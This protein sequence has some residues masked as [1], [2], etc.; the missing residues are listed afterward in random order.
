MIMK[1]LNY[2][3]VIVVEIALLITVVSCKKSFLQVPA[4]G[5]LNKETLANER[6]LQKLLTG[7]YAD[8]RGT[9]IPNTGSAWENSPDN[10]IYG[11]IAGGESH[12]GSFGGDQPGIN[13]IETWNV[14]PSNGFLNDRW[15]GLYDGI[16]RAN[17]VL[18][19]VKETSDVSKEKKTNIIAQARFL[20]GH[21]YFQLKEMFNM[22]PWIYENTTNFNQ[23]NDKDIWPNIEADFKFA[24]NNLPTTQNEVG[25]VN[26]WA[27]R[28]YLGKSYLYEGKYDSAAVVFNDVISN[29]E[30]SNGLKYR[31]VK[32]FEDNY[33]SS[34]KNN[35]ESVFA[36]QMTGP[37]GTNSIANSNEGDMLN[38]P[39]GDAPFRRNGGFNQPS[40]DLVNSYRTNA[41]GLPMVDNYNQHPIKN[42]LGISSDKPFT[43]DKGN[44]DPRL[45][46]T[47]GRRGIPYLDW[48]PYPGL[49][50]V[51]T[52]SY[53]GPFG[54]KK[55][56][57][58][59]ATQDKYAN[60]SSWAPG[61]A[62]NV[63]IIRF[64]GV[65]LMAAE[66]DAHLGRLN[67]AEKYVN[68]VRERAVNPSG[69]VHK[70]KDPSN[71]LEGFSNTP[72][73]NY[74]ISTYPPGYFSK[75][76]KEK[77]LHHIHFEEKLEFGMEGHRFFNLSRWGIAARFLNK[78]FQYE[79]QYVTAVQG[80]HFTKGKNE[81][82]PIPQQQ[83]DKSVING[84]PRLKQNSGYK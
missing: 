59:Q 20:R 49:E 62:Q 70:Y 82:F 36:V 9:E 16:G 1:R 18:K 74:V 38:F 65:L 44:I 81:Y 75:I 4:K 14:T 60:Q 25:R 41:K 43:P 40:I 57:Y 83:I 47:V 28:A 6:G 69:W 46:W 3:F 48:G 13:P 33:R 27:A 35:K 19:I 50:W 8:L 39:G 26:K 78:Y 34:T 32:E 55:T 23:P 84:K 76:G 21:Y 51:L 54:P 45:D 77:A 15:K 10:W 30:T 2:T 80:A 73:A 63:L 52:P 56:T 24:Y 7:A 42:S 64:A 22:V 53:A 11:D 71:P 67:Q 37:N 12:K 72:A 58:W 29:G 31:L 66:A 68:R 17:S 79:S 61:D 5:S